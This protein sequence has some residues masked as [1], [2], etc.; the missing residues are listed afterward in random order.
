MRPIPIQALYEQ[1]GQLTAGRDRSGQP[2]GLGTTGEPPR[3]DSEERV[4]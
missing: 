1:G 3:I 2:H 4:T